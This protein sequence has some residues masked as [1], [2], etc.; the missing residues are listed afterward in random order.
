[1]VASWGLEIVAFGG[2]GGGKWMGGGSNVM[3]STDEGSLGGLFGSSNGFQVEEVGRDIF[4]G[5]VACGGR[6]GGEGG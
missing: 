5:K 4:G 2:G 6:G 3:G 1:M